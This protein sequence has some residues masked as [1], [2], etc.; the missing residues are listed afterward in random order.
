MSINAKLNEIPR[1][2]FTVVVKLR[3]F[4][5]VIALV[6]SLFIYSKI[7]NWW[8]FHRAPIIAELPAWGRVSIATRDQ[9]NK[10]CQWQ[11]RKSD[12]SLAHE[13]SIELTKRLQSQ[14]P[15]GTPETQIQRQLLAQD[16]QKDDWVANVNGSKKADAKMR[17]VKMNKHYSFTRRGFIVEKTT[18]NIAWGLDGNGSVSN[19]RGCVIKTFD[20]M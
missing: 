6:A 4:W 2:L 19:I 3:W 20:A 13:A 7:V 10:L 9:A 14:F 1:A 17:E 8:F 5:V 11:E 18:W 12:F 15:D 16:F